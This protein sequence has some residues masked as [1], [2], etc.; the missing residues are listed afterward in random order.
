MKALRWSFCLLSLA[1]LLTACGPTRRT[2]AT[3]T[4]D[5]GRFELTILQLND[6]YE[7][8]PL[9]DGSGGLARVATI[10][11]ELL[12][13]NPNTLTVLAGDFISPSVIGTLKF[14]GKRI[15]GRQMV[16]VLNTLGLDWVVFGNHE[17][18]YDDLSDLQARLDESRFGWL[19]ANALLKT[20]EGTTPFYQTRDGL[21]RN[22]PA[23]T[24]LVLKD[25]DGT[26]LRLGLFGVLI[27]TGRKSWVQYTDYLAAG[28]A[29]YDGL[30]GRSD[31]AL[32]ITHLALEDDKQLAAALPGL[33]LIIGGHE[34]EHSRTIGSTVIAKADANAKTIYVHHLSYNRKTGQLKL[35]S[36]L[37]PINASIPEEPQTAAIV[38]KWE[39]IKAEALA[40]SGFDAGR[41]VTELKTPLDCREAT[42]RNG[43]APAG[44]MITDA[45]LA[46]AKQSP[47]CAILNSGSIRVDDVLKG[48]LT[49][50]DVVR[51]LPFGGAIVEVDMRGSLL[52]RTLNTS[53]ENAK[54]G[55]YLQWARIRLE[56]TDTWFINNAPLDDATYYRV[57][58][59]DFS[60]QATNRTWPSSKPNQQPPAPPIPKYEPSAKP[61]PPTKKISATISAWQ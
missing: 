21:R 48:T 19:S 33:P 9:S 7:I 10:R 49:E 50:L 43:Q 44:K 39:R 29:S 34:H 23:D 25:A 61:P 27:N 45:M 53:V 8:S 41:K 47:D 46:A 3:G 5:D 54:S 52:R 57:V 51:M 37:R 28:K 31:V 56:G 24:V 22:C 55:G 18:D 16:D 26:T 42:I 17:F 20:A 30:K 38:A 14:D 2:T 15:R 11:K 6:V 59:P 35:R 60:S 32:G 36:D 4:T 13:A 12:A 40:S 1:A 58:L